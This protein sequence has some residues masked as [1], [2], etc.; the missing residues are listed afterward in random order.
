MIGYQRHAVM[1]RRRRQ[2]DAVTGIALALAA[3]IL[4]GCGRAPVT[5]DQPLFE[6]AVVTLAPPDPEWDRTVAQALADLKERQDRGELGVPRYLENTTVLVNPDTTAYDHLV[7]SGHLTNDELKRV[8]EIQIRFRYDR[9]TFNTE[10][11]RRKT[12][13][14]TRE[15]GR[16]LRDLYQQRD[17]QLFIVLGEDRAPRVIAF[18]KEHAFPPAP[19]TAGPY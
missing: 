4:P 6:E 2:R 11:R 15:Y 3:C 7:Q 10:C 16:L 5:D 19:R 13:I 14:P 1:E 9:Y 18:L 8:A 17:R 12:P